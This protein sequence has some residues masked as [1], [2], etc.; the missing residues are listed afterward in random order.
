MLVVRVDMS[1]DDSFKSV[2][3]KGLEHVPKKNERHNVGGHKTWREE[4]AIDQP[5]PDFQVDY[6]VQVG[7]SK[8]EVTIEYDGLRHSGS[9]DRTGDKIRYPIGNGDI[10]FTKQ[11]DTDYKNTYTP[12]QKEGVERGKDKYEPLQK[13][14]MYGLRVVKRNDGQN[15]VHV[16]YMQDLT[17]DGSSSG[18]LKEL[19]HVT[20]HGQFKDKDGN[21]SKPRTDYKP[22]WRVGPRIDGKNSE[23]EPPYTKG[24]LVKK[25]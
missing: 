18:P 25:L 22:D 1:D 12:G 14:K 13:G 7:D 21:S 19:M 11:I 6:V 2:I 4:L 16:A 20:D 15:T 5:G 3:G 9:N 17:E 24:V 10:T 8:D 23:H